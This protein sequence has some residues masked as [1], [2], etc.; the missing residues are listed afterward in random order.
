LKNRRTEANV[1]VG[2][3]AY[4]EEKNIAF[5]LKNLLTQQDLPLSSEVI[6][7]CSGCTDSTP[8][9]VKNL[10]SQDSRLKLII[11]N[12]RKGKAHAL[13]YIFK[14]ASNSEVLILTNA[15]AFPESGSLNKLVKALQNKSLGAVAG[16]PI[17]VNNPS[18]L[19]NVIVR[20]IWDLHHRISIYESV[21]MSGE[22]CAFRP[23]LVKEIPVNLATD[24]PYIE[25]LIR[26]RG[27]NVGYVPEAI[28]F[29][30]GPENLREIIKHRRRI[31]VGHLQIKQMEGFVVSTSDFRKILSTLVKSFRLS[32][33]EL[34]AIALFI[35]L[36]V[37]SYLLARYDLSK[38]RIPFV[39]ETLGSTKKSQL[40]EDVK[41]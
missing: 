4:N 30:K 17:P 22:L 38:G 12:E 32:L 7:A 21:K 27:Y 23:F 34:A 33:S 36:D 35:P 41:I 25:M 31:W 10:Q 40:A 39:W 11:E 26:R 24:E 20:L 9:I 13:N 18:V 8:E 5:L 3:C 28:V 16:H 14:Y 6:V 1:S 19:S 37:Y 2:V 29:I 15:D